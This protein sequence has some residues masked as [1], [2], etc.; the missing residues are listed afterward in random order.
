MPLG[1]SINL[2]GRGCN[3]CEMSQFFCEFIVGDN[4]IYKAHKT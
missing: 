1:L 3:M 2:Y 4:K